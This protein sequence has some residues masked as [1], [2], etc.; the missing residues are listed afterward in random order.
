MNQ[1]RKVLHN[2]A[3][4]AFVALG[5]SGAAQAALVVG[6]FD[7]EFG[8]TTLTNTSFHGI[9]NFNISQDCL[10]LALP[11]GG[12]FIYASYDCGGGGS[13]MS[14]VSAHVDFTNTMTSAPTGSVD[15]SASATAILG[16][17]V[18]NGKVIG[19]QSEVIGPSTSTLPGFGDPKFD[20]LFGMLNPVIGTDEGHPPGPDPVSDF[21][22]DDLPAS[23]FQTTSLFLVSSGCTPGGTNPCEQSNAATTRYVPEPGS[24]TLALAALGVGWLVRRK[25]PGARVA[26]TT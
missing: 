20:L 11:T 19:V 22:L 14:F 1:F 23:T 21:D 18:L 15:F 12:A 3:V 8:G 13:G 26:R 9:A 7:P 5:A 10:N 16:M 2:A 6:V 4:G 17:Y 25:K 24:M